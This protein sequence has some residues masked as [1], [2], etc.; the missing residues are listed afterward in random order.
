MTGTRLKRI[1]EHRSDRHLISREGVEF[2]GIDA[3]DGLQI[4]VLLHGSDA[5]ASQAIYSV[6]INWRR[7]R[8]TR[9]GADVAH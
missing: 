7:N 4:F 3:K 5:Y 8:R 2:N 6:H 9:G 1:R